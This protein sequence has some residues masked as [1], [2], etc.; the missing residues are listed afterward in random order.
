MINLACIFFFIS[1]CLLFT[2]KSIAQRDNTGR[3]SSI[4]KGFLPIHNYSPKEYNARPQNWAIVQDKRGVMYFGNNKGVLEYDGVNWR[5]INTPNETTVR[6]LS[7]DE[8]GRIYIGARGEFGYLSPD[9]IGNL[10]YKSLLKYVNKKDR[11]FAD[12]WKTFATDEGVFFQTSDK[13]FRWR[14]NQFKVWNADKSFHFM[15]YLPS[16][17]KGVNGQIYVSEREIGLKKL[18][19]DDLVLIQGGELF[20]EESIYFMIPFK[21]KQILLNTRS[22]GL[23]IMTPTSADYYPT[24]RHNPEQFT[25]IV[26]FHSKIDSFLM[27]NLVYSAIRLHNG[28]YS[29]GT[30]EGGIAIID[31][32]GKLLYFLNKDQGLQ[33]EATKFQY[34]DAQK[35][36][37]IALN[38]GISSVDISSPITFFDDKADLE[39]TIQ[40]IT[41]YNGTLYVATNL[42]VYYLKNK[43]S[44]EKNISDFE[45]D[46]F[47]K[48]EG[49]STEC[50]D[51]KSF[52]N[53]KH[54]VLLVTTNDGIFQIDKD[55]R[56]DFIT[57]N[58]PWVFHQSKE[59]PSRVFIGLENGLSSIYRS[60]GKWIDEGNIEG[61]DETIFNIAE[62]NDGDLWLGTFNQGVLLLHISSFVNNRIYE[63]EIVRYD[64]SNGLPEGFVYV[65][66]AINKT[67][68][69]TGKG[70][71]EYFDDYEGVHAFRQVSSFGAIFAEGS[72]GIHRLAEDDNGNIWMV[73]FSKKDV[74][75]GFLISKENGEA[76]WV[77]KPF[78][79][80][81]KEIIHAIYHDENGVTWL[82]G[83]EG[84]YRYDANV[85]KDYEKDFYTLI[86]KVV[87]GKDSVIFWGANF[88]EDGTI[89]AYQLESLKPTL[90]YA[91]NSLTF[92]FAAQSYENESVNHF[93]YY[94]EGF[95]DEWTN[96]KKE[97]KAVYTNLPEGTYYF[98]VKA[99][100]TY[101]HES[102]EA[103][104]EFTILPPWYRTIWA[105]IGYVLSFVGF[106]YG[107]VTLSTRGLQKIIRE[108]TAEVVRQKEEIEGKNKDI[109]D[110]IN[111]AKKIQDAILPT[112]DYIKS[113]LPDS[114][115][116]YKPKD[117]VSGDFYWLTEVNQN[118]N[119]THIIAAADCTG[120]GVPGAFMSMIGNSL[121]NEIVNDKGITE[122]A[123]ILQTLKKGVIKSLKQSGE[124]GESQD[125]MDI[126]VCAFD[127]KENKVEYAG[128]NN[129]LYLIR[130]SELIVTKPDRM[131]IG[132]YIGEKPHFTNHEIA[133][134]K[135]DIIY[136]FSDGF[137]DQ[138]GGPQ[139]KKFMSKRF[140]QLFLDMKEMSMAEQK[141]HLD[142]TIEEWK[143]I[144][145]P[146]TGQSY[147]QMDDILVIGIKV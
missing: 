44:S 137:I 16:P 11:K 21:E 138:F 97:A 43:N 13:I 65:R 40:S 58:I 20:A 60:N 50:W 92:E 57:K 53:G 64:T 37:W 69:S 143:V 109:T 41:R 125:G 134:Q 105:Y 85:E 112:N 9:S 31:S 127:F 111:Y 136:I 75:V 52:N 3:Q 84:L 62:D 80:I 28:N 6:S 4:E 81:S 91:M 73:T 35:R 26:P 48:I 2:A 51:L 103:V 72:R 77:N 121:L 78:L 104:Y 120:H 32:V 126:A 108:R 33:D 101:E 135:E 107:A 95:D 5:Q 79:G 100:N 49:I 18:I 22:H 63:S 68:F 36:L 24:N 131:P 140:K 146:S 93:T 17:S 56:I 106:V 114:F 47:K 141:T 42:G 82:G 15:F 74:E 61:I 1:S 45:R 94:L 19:D 122:P 66:Q 128:A 25:K 54:N 99:K 123:K 142:K 59:D 83:P 145:N 102:I 87:L 129:P 89:S 8:K 144:S 71:Y 7:I 133:I 70:L 113:L 110:S 119:P 12:V 38:N 118:G 34:I 76:S 86:R 55:H 67:L 98:R 116:L 88:D 147:E 10:K 132:I 39:G 29:I 117:I 90:P 115:I 139:G 30:S 130:N 23:Y 14:D 27:K 124:K 46:V 96:W